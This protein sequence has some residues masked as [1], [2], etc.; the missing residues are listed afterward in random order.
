MV[1]SYSLSHFWLATVQEVLQ[2]DWQEAWHSPQPPFA[3][4]S[5]RFALFS[6]LMC[7][8]AFIK[9]TLSEP[10][11]LRTFHPAAAVDMIHPYHTISFPQIQPIFCFGAEPAL[12]ITLSFAYAHSV[13]LRRNCYV[14][15]IRHGT[16][17]LCIFYL[18]RHAPWEGRLPAVLSVFS[19][20]VFYQSTRACCF[21]VVDDYNSFGI[22]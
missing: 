10:P 13:R 5:F 7:F 1:F 17:G 16:A 4:D 20:S 15:H 11:I 2:A 6:V 18:R 12:P 19:G 22:V 14:A 9:I 3:A 8:V 21:A